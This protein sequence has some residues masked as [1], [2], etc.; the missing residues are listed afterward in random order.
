LHLCP[1]DLDIEDGGHYMATPRQQNGA[2]R[3]A[4]GLGWFSIG[5]G[6]AEVAAPATVAQLIGIRDTTRT[7]GVMRAF[8][9]REIVSGIG[10][11]SSRPHPAWLWAR[12]AG[13]VLDIAALGA[14]PKVV[15]DRAR[16]GTAFA[17]LA[18][19][20]VADVAAA[21]DGHPSRP[22]RARPI[23][24]AFTINRA[25]DDVAQL[26]NELD[27]LGDVVE[28]VRFDVAP[29]DRGTEVR[30][31]FHPRWFG[32]KS[33]ARVQEL[34]RQFKQLAET[35]EV[36]RSSASGTLRKTGDMPEGFRVEELLVG[37]AR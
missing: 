23:S 9:V 13:D 32:R 5:L 26:W 24:K 16:V 6:L 25:P 27:P 7:R 15:G 20:L 19:A 28:H 35:G 12:V 1:P 21:R 31:Q 10:I 4:D 11:L 18:G 22:D 36:A 14:A 3:L 17:S 34:L 30:V 33:P 37:G 8:G 29:G 2:S